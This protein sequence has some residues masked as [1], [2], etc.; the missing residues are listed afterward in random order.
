MPCPPGGTGATRGWDAARC[1]WIG[2][3]RRFRRSTRWAQPSS[4]VQHWPHDW[5]AKAV[6]SPSV[7]AASS[8]EPQPRA[9]SGW[10]QSRSEVKARNVFRHAR[11]LAEAL[12]YR[13]GPN[14]PLLRVNRAVWLGG[15]QVVLT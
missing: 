7:T 4:T 11:S 12:G 15:P 8:P 14:V 2:T 1:G 10:C 6:C 5:Q 13:S 9:P 3:R